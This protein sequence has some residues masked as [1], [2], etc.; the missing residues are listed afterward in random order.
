MVIKYH[1]DYAVLFLICDR[2]CYT[3]YT[4]QE[5]YEIILKVFYNKRVRTIFLCLGIGVFGFQEI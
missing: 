1:M 5:V 3:S 2:V 4:I